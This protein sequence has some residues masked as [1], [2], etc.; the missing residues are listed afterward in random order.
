MQTMKLSIG[1][2]QYFWERQQ[3]LC[4]YQQ[5]ADSPAEIIYLGEVI[6][7]KRR[8]VKTKDWIAIGEELRQS[9]KEVILSSLTLLEAASETGALKKLC[10][11]EDFM[12]EANDIS[13][14]QLLSAAGKAFVTGPSVNIYN[15]HSLRLLAAKG[16]KRWVLPV[17]LGLKTLADMQAARP[18]GIETEVFALGRL[19]L[20]YSARCYTARSH[21]LPKDNCQ[22]KCLDYP[23]GRML[24]TR[25][26]QE[27]LILN[28]TQTQSALTHQ[29]LEKLPELAKLGVDVLRISPQSSNTLEI[30]EIFDSAR[31][32]PEIKPTGDELLKLLP[33]GACNGYLVGKAGLDYEVNPAA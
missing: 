16:L 9:G 11:N 10:N 3:V 30:I 31:K 13:A 22:F 14:V 6:C 19:P 20:A 18:A 29:V 21:N 17:E 33:A 2:I 8:L 4:F 15:Q 25:E 7:S 5:V 28:G 23:D 27:F 32:A 12:V 26:N 24:K 1:P